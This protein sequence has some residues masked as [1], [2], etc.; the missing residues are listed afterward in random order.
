MPSRH[1]CTRKSKE[2]PLNDLVDRPDPINR[3]PAR[4]RR[5]LV[6]QIRESGLYPPL[7]VRPLPSPSSKFE[8]VDGHLRRDVLA[9]L[10]R[11]SARCEIWPVAE[12][13]ADLLAMSLNQLRG[14]ADQQRRARRLRRLIR[15]WGRDAVARRLAL[16][17]ANIRQVLRSGQPAPAREKSAGLDLRPVF[18]HLH[19]AQLKE[20]EAALKAAH[21]STTGRG[22]ALMKLIHKATAN[23]S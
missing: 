16:S 1:R 2:I 15:R 6:E 14:R 10:G 13:A 12:E 18:F 22:E 3:M 21:A 7:I 17:P 19:P 4:T 9:Q 11:R 8:I 20:L 23:P 5:A